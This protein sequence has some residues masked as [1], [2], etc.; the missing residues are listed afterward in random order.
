M[1]HYKKALF[2]VSVPGFYGKEKE[3]KELEKWLESSIPNESLEEKNGFSSCD[4]VLGSFCL[5]QNWFEFYSE[6]ETD[7]GWVRPLILSEENWKKFFENL[8]DGVWVCTVNYQDENGELQ[9][10]H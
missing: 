6:A 7:Y 3:M 8:R 10:H 1:G 9:G 2:S 5:D 4:T